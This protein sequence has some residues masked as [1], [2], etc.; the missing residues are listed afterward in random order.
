MLLL[1][2]ISAVTLYSLVS[3][4]GNTRYVTG[5][6]HMPLNSYCVHCTLNPL[7]MTWGHVANY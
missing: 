5:A 7:T 1:A 3:T 4:I 2:D 6:A